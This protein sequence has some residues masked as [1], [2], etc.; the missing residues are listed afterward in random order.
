MLFSSLCRKAF[1][2]GVATAL[3][4]PSEATRPAAFSLFQQ[5]ASAQTERVEGDD[6]EEGAREGNVSREEERYPAT[7]RRTRI[8]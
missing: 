7:R 4:L 1:I 2:A 3:P 8:P 5:L 6:G